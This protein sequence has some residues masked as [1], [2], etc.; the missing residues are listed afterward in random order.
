MT[1]QNGIA[2]FDYD[3]FAIRFPEFDELGMERVK[4]YWDEANI[5]L[6]NDATSPIAWAQ[7]GPILNLMA[8]HIAALNAAAL[9]GQL[10]S[11]GGLVGRISSASEGSVSV[12]LEPMG[13]GSSAL[14]AWLNQTRYGSLLWAML[15]RYLVARYIPGRQP[16]LGVRPFGQPSLGGML[17]QWWG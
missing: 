7:R 13:T 8:A 12:S 6:K 2:D 9:P 16:Y 11:S 3:A 17:G 5:F 14:G 15:Q 10:A 4:A 1:E